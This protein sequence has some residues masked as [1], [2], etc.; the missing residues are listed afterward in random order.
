MDNLHFGPLIWS[1]VGKLILMLQ[2]RSSWK[3]WW[4]SAW[5]FVVPNQG[6]K[7]QLL[8]IYKE[9]WNAPNGLITVSK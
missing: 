5:Q 8:Q 3:L 2:E 4:L 1:L 7:P 6:H 9:R